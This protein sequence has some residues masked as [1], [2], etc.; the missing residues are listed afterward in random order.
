MS[1]RRAA[2]SRKLAEWVLYHDA[3]IELSDLFEGRGNTIEGAHQDA[4][5]RIE[6]QLWHGT[7]PT[8]TLAADDFVLCFHAPTLGREWR[9]GDAGEIPREFWTYYLETRRQ[10]H[11]EYDRRVSHPLGEGNEANCGKSA[12]W[13][14][15][16][17]GW[18]E[19]GFM[20]GHASEVLLHRPSIEGLPKR[21]G[22]RSEGKKDSYGYAGAVARIKAE[23]DAAEGP[24]AKRKARREGI[25]RELADGIG[26]GTL[27]NRWRHLARKLR[28]A[29]CRTYAPRRST[30]KSGDFL[31]R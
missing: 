2:G 26:K 8:K 22:E 11:Q 20:E 23:V 28:E 27:D 31:L 9:L 15:S 19:G 12:F 25:E 24:D 1:T 3:W 5:R 7:L 13:F 30:R 4:A 18:K 16:R 21:R 14:V 17:Q 6:Q 29:G 10:V